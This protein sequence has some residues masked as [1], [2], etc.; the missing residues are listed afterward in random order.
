MRSYASFSPAKGQRKSHTDTVKFTP[1]L[2]SFFFSNLH[3]FSFSSSSFPSSFPST[4]PIHVIVP[5]L[6]PLPSSP[7]TAAKRV[8]ED[9]ISALSAAASTM[10]AIRPLWELHILNLPISS[11]AASVVLRISLLFFLRFLFIESSLEKGDRTLMPTTPSATAPPSPPSSSHAPAASMTPSPSFR[12]LRRSSPSPSPWPRPRLWPPKPPPLALVLA[13]HGVAH[14]RRRHALR[15]HH[16]VPRRLAHAAQGPAL[17]P[18][19]P[20]Q[21]RRRKRFVHRTTSLHDLKCV[22]NAMGC[23]ST[24]PFPPPSPL[25]L[26][27]PPSSLSI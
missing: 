27:A 15:C 20:A 5:D 19:G 23:M 1:F 18:R 11:I 25:P 3:H 2:F 8:V 13:R 16:H 17:A 22:K 6:S 24:L 12:P 7:A 21:H 9:Y 4:F 14:P 10:D 26:P